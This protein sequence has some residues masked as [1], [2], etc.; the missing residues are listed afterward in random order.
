MR[1]M[2]V[3]AFGGADALTPARL[4]D[5]APGPGEVTVDVV[6]AAV[7]FVDVLMRRGAFSLP[8]PLTPGLSIAGYV[9]ALGAGVTGLRVGQAVAAFTAPPAMGGYATRVRVSA[10]FVVP[11]DTPDGPVA[12]DRAA[13]S[14]V[15]GSTAYL[16]LVELGSLQPGHA[17]VVQ[18]A[19]GALGS[20]FAR[21]ARHLGA[22]PLI[23]VVSSAAR[24]ASTLALGYTH[25]LVA[26]EDI[27]SQVRAV[28]GGRGA[29][30]V[31]DPVGGPLRG[32][33]LAALRPLGR[34]IVV[35]Q[36][37]LE[38]EEPI[39]ARD[40]WLGS[41]A[42][43]GLN[44]GAL[45][46]AQPSRFQRAARAVFALVARGDLPV[47]VARVLPL[48][49]AAEAHHRLERCGVAGTMLLRVGEEERDG[50]GRQPDGWAASGIRG[51]GPAAA[52]RQSGA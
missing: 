40:L 22:D 14:I 38:P 20:T 21:L 51:E 13:A 23:G 3:R 49:A 50:R 41:H 25:V 30:L 12:L 15:D 33:S 24:R 48:S 36:S 34:L 39:S 19:A 9:R 43:L 35:G 7:G 32:V 52:S 44:F 4:P 17:V 18:G 26:S 1:A 6:F 5:P 37:S 10:A 28:T 45:A 16:A 46:A 47:D 8:L 11:V 42:V 29:D 2:T 27:G 31:V